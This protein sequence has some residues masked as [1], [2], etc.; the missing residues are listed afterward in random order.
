MKRGLSKT[1]YHKK[2]NPMLWALQQSV[3]QRGKVFH[4]TTLTQSIRSKK[5]RVNSLLGLQQQH[6]TGEHFA[7]YLSVH[8]SASQHA[9]V[10]RQW[11]NA[12]QVGWL[13]LKKSIKF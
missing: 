4:S 6:A 2:S 10:L 9:L 8:L 12:M 11:L 13:N 1:N 5:T 7:L 3:K